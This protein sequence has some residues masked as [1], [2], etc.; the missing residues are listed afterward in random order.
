MPHPFASVG[1]PPALGP[2]SRSVKQM[3]RTLKSDFSLSGLK[4]GREEKGG[5][6]MFWWR[7]WWLVMV[8]WCLHF[9]VV[10]GSQYMEQQLNGLT[11]SETYYAQ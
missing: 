3:A 4:H 8:A 2:C 11:T 7:F 5:G 1:V 6:A 10:N 9:G